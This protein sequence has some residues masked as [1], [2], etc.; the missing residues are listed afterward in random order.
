MD[1]AQEHAQI[2][3]DKAA[4]ADF[5]A[6]KLKLINSGK[7]TGADYSQYFQVLGDE[8]GATTGRGRSVGW[9]DVPWLQ[10]A[11]RIN[12]PRWIALTRFDMLSGVETV[13]VVVGYKYGGET[14]P[15]GKIPAPWE[16]NKIEIIKEDWPGFTED[17]SGIS[18][19][20]DLPKAAREFLSRLEKHL[21]VPILLVGTGPA[22]EAI[23]VRK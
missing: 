5:L 7:A 17:I 6:E 10:Y 18:D 11:I 19:E 14:L 4:A 23:I 1:F 8:R 12:K 20:K 9:L 21:Q 16:F 15:A 22:R 13:P 2:F 3:V